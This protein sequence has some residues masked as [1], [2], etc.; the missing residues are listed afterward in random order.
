MEG[1]FRVAASLQKQLQTFVPSCNAVVEHLVDTRADVVPNF[2]PDFVGSRPEHPVPLDTHSRKVGVVAEERLFRPPE[3]P[4]GK[5][6]VQ[7]DT[8]DCLQALRPLRWRAEP[9][10]RPVERP[11]ARAHLA[12]ALQK[13]LL[14]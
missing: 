6:R 2:G 12:P 11:H 7:H 3:H 13:C 9:S 5:P 1:F 8:H 4:H 14:V 10:R